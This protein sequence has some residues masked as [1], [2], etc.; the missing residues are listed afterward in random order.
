MKPDYH[1]SLLTKTEL[2][3]HRY[4]WTVTA[5]RDWSITPHCYVFIMMENA[6]KTNPC[7]NVS[8]G[9]RQHQSLNA[10]LALC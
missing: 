7:V 6:N 9:T 8:N 5:E 10:A 4:T 3:T 1:W 2:E